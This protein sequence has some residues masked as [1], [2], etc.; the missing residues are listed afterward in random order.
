MLL[1]L[2]KN[3]KKET[4]IYCPQSFLF[5]CCMCARSDIFS[6][7]S[8]HFHLS[9]LTRAIHQKVNYISS[10]LSQLPSERILLNAVGGI[11][12]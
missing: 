2:C 7:C 4:L 9:V 3:K 1:K 10:V 12:K 5:L 6:H 8:K 11:I